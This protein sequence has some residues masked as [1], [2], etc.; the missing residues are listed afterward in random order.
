MNVIALLGAWFVLAWGVALV[1]GP[2][3]KRLDR[4]VDGCK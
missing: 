1:V 3:L 4:S 2:A